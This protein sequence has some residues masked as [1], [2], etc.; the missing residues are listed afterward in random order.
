[1]LQAKEKAAQKQQEMAQEQDDNFTELCN[2]VH[3][4]TLTENPAVA[5][6]AFGPHRYS[7]V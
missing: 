1:M 5:Q 6:S 4:D 7:Y 2:H 3:G